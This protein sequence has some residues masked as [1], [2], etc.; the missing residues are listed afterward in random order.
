MSLFR[1]FL[2]VLAAAIS[3]DYVLILIPPVVAFGQVVNKHMPRKHSRHNF[4]RPCQSSSRSMSREN[5]RDGGE[6]GS[7]K[8]ILG[9]AIRG[10]QSSAFKETIEAGDTVVC[11][12]EVPSLGIYEN[13]SYEL[14]SIYAQY[15]DKETQS[16]IKEPL[17]SL[18]DRIP[19]GSEK[20]II[21]F[22]PSYHK[23]PVIVSPE[24]VGLSSV[25]N[26]LGSAALLAVPGF[27]WVFVASSFYNIYHERTGGSFLDAFLGR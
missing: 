25:R 3:C 14:K 20:Y 6:D 11:K 8:D 17:D 9:R 10:F 7:D 16:I 24:E 2:L 4:H 22:S 18:D 21:L 23:E 26:E 15:F 27:F 12:Q 19:P 5:N 1:L 13:A